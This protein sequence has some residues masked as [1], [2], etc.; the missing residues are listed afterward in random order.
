MKLDNFMDSW[1]NNNIIKLTVDLIS[2][3]TLYYREVY[4]IHNS[5]LKTKFTD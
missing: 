1:N 4:P 2:Q 5:T 3:V